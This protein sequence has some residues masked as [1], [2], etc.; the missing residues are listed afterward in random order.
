MKIKIPAEFKIWINIKNEFLNMPTVI[1]NGCYMV[2]INCTFLVRSQTPRPLNLVSKS[3]CLEKLF[4]E[5]IKNW[6]FIKMM[7]SHIITSPIADGGSNFP[8]HI[9]FQKTSLARWGCWWNFTSKFMI[10]RTSRVRFHFIYQS[11]RYNCSLNCEHININVK[12]KWS[13]MLS[14]GELFQKSSN[15]NQIKCIVRNLKLPKQVYAM[16]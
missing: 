6:F 13:L 16:T 7:F 15:F 9:I 10:K 3:F 11:Y 14:L 4:H 8:K 2:L 12:N 5:L 1:L